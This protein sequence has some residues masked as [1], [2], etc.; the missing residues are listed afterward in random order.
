M[1]CCKLLRY[2]A[3]Q[4]FIL[5]KKCSGGSVVQVLVYFSEGQGSSPKASVGPLSK[6]V[7][8]ICPRCA[9]SYLTPASNKIS[10]KNPNNFTVLYVTNKGFFLSHS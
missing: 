2:S 6:P 10:K 9:L 4:G 8:P 5:P 1:G 7:N 3:S